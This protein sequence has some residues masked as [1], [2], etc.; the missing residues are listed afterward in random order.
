MVGD[1]YPEGGARRDAG[2]SVFYMGINTGAFIGP[3]IC[4]SLGERINW[5]WGS[6]RPGSAWSSG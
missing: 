6:A 2:F 3:I 1:L 4:G 5:H